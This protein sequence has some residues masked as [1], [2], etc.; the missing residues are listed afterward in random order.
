MRTNFHWLSHWMSS[1]SS[2]AML[3]S[4]AVSFAVFSA[5]VAEWTPLQ[6]AG[7]ENPSSVSVSPDGEWVVF[8]ISGVATVGG[9]KLAPA[10]SLRL[11][12]A[13]GDPDQRA[14]AVEAFCA[15]GGCSMPTFAADLS[16]VFLKKGALWRSERGVDAFSPPV[17]V[18]APAGSTGR[19]SPIIAYAVSPDAT[20][21][22]ATYAEMGTYSDTEGRVITT[23]VIVN[24][25][26][27]TPQPERNVLCVAP[28]AAGA[29]NA[30]NAVSSHCYTDL[31]GSVGM[32]GWRISCW[33]YD[34]QMSWSRSDNKTLAVTV[35][36]N[37]LANEWESVRVALIDATDPAA[38]FRF[39]GDASSPP[40]FQPTFSPDGNTLAFTQVRRREILLVV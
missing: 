5:A 34:S 31:P 14:A 10:G 38:V 20:A 29:A 25:I 27:G 33:P 32:E 35:T 40:S 6:Q 16:V 1:M 18:Y 3:L 21:V 15:D 23:D 4:F 39:V 12:L 2:R 9:N 22:A 28:F 11:E 13:S 17:R 30:T 19:S 26:T 37:R 36:S 8:S 7:V 24:V